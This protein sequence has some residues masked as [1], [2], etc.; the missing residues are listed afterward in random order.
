MPDDDFLAAFEECVWPHDQWHHREHV[1]VAYL[2]LLRHG[3]RQSSERL[4]TAIRAYNAAHPRPESLTTGYHETLTQA[5]L[6]LVHAA[7]CQHGP[8]PSADEFFDRHPELWQWQ[9]A[10]LFY[11]AERLWS[12][13]AK[14]SFVEPDLA[15]L[16]ISPRGG[17]DW[18]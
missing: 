6:R 10:R 16:P 14:I 13:E 15:P 4:P 3:L 9:I 12:A 11:S 7:L 2:Y 18:M 8:A 5:W 17:Y 1:K